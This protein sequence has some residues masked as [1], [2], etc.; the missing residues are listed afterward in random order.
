L[1]E[2][3]IFRKQEEFGL[4]CLEV[5]KLDPEQLSQREKKD[6]IKSYLEDYN[7]VTLPHEK[8]YNL[9]LWEE[10]ETRR[11]L[12]KQQKEEQ[13][14]KQE[15]EEGPIFNDEEQLRLERKRAR[16][17]KANDEYQERILSTSIARIE[18]E[19]ETMKKILEA[20]INRLK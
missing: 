16:D 19:R 10:N 12:K 5:K 8:Y 15:D 11:K 13:R 14:K 2:V 6:L 7:T 18:R 1:R 17:K 9:H 20:S 4:W 3:D